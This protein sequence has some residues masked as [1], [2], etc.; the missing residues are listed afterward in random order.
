MSLTRARQVL[1]AERC[2]R[3]AHFLIFDSQKLLTK[4]EHDQDAPVKPV[5]DLPYLRILLDCYLVSGRMLEPGAAKYALAGGV[6]ASFLEALASTGML[7]VEKSRDMFVTNLTCAYLLARGRMRAHQLILLQ[8]KKEEDAAK[9]VFAKEPQFARL[10]FMEDHLPPHLRQ[11][12]WPGGGAYGNLYVPNGTQFRAIPEGGDIIRSEHPS[13]I[14]ADEAAFQP[15]FGASYTAALPAVEGGG[16]YLAISSAAPSEFEAV[17]DAK[18]DTTP[19][20]VPG[21]GWRL[22]H[23][24]VPVLRLHYAADPAKRPGTVDGDAWRRRAAA[25]YVGGVGSP[26]WKQEMEIEYGALSGT[27]LFP[28]WEAWAQGPL[29]CDPFVPVG[30]QLYGSY[31]HGWNNPACYY[32]HGRNGDGEITTL[33]EFYADRVPL[34][35]IAKLIKGEDVTTPPR[36]EAV[37]DEGRREFPGNPFAGDEVWR[38][39]DPS[40]WAEDKPQQDQ[41]NKSTAKLFREEGVFFKPGQRGGD[42]T[43][44]EW[45]LS[46]FWH[47]PT[48]P[49]YRISRECTWLLWELGRQRFKDVS[50]MVAQHQNPSEALVDK[51]NHAWD[52]LKMFLAEFPPGPA[53]PRAQEKGNTFEWWKKQVQRT[54]QGRAVQSYARQMI[55]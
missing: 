17:V 35:C 1:E 25:R 5:P 3:D 29:V 30:Y 23:G 53:R 44:A 19:T 12:Q 10:S 27:K 43:V 48:T 16:Q 36:P 37:I 4:D 13:V 22:S 38:V 14:F 18:G 26:R 49:R 42:T 32:I 6:P 54:K 52:A 7:F 15:Q 28:D 24:S 45:L 8:S 33:W 55:G 40:M 47:D 39:A 9:L 2:R 46:Y 11:I 51:D 20:Q 31:D 34:N 21:L 41:P 50:A